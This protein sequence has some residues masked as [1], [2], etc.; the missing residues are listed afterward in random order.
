M[1]RGQ[2]GL[3]EGADS[4]QPAAHSPQP[5]IVL[6]AS[7]RV[8]SEVLARVR[9]GPLAMAVGCRLLAVGFGEPLCVDAPGDIADWGH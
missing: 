2:V 1:L 8:C 3:G 5:T 9:R 4:P 6:G 7:L